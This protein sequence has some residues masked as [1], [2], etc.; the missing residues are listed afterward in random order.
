MQ[1]TGLYPQLPRSMLSSATPAPAPATART[2][3]RSHTE[4]RA[5]WRNE[6]SRPYAA[7]LTS[8]ARLR[9][10]PRSSA[11][12]AVRSA[13]AQKPTPRHRLGVSSGRCPHGRWPSPSSSKQADMRSAARTA[14]RQ[15]ASRPGGCACSAVAACAAVPPRRVA[16]AVLH[17][18]AHRY[19]ARCSFTCVGRPPV[20][21]EWAAKCQL[22]GS[23][24]RAVACSGS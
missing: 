21:L 16:M 9:E 3:T 11:S 19:A 1:P 7:S 6:A 4:A 5:G 14:P 8:R 13:F 20:A 10:A 22:W 15:A 24:P 12:A 18:P 23:N 17:K 2:T